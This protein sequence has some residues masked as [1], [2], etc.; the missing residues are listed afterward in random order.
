M[1]WQWGLVVAGVAAVVVVVVVVVAAVVLVVRDDGSPPPRGVPWK[2]CQFPQVLTRA[3]RLPAVVRCCVVIAI[4]IC[5]ATQT[6]D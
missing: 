5:G 4:V 3:K 1:P 2:P 6:I